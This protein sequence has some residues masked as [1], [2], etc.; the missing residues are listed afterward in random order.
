[1]DE[2]LAALLQF[3]TIVFAGMLAMS[4]AY[5]ALVIVGAAHINPFHGAEGAVKGAVHGMAGAVKGAAHVVDGGAAKANALTEALA[6]LGLSRVPIT[7]S[8]SVFSLFAWFIS[9][10]TRQALDASLGATLSTLAASGA[11][12]AGGFVATALVSKPIAGIFTEP[13]GATSASLTGKTVKVTTEIADD[14][15]GQGEIDDGGAGITIT[16]RTAPGVS[17]KRGDEALVIEY[18]DGAGTYLVEPRRAIAPTD[19]EL[20]AAPVE[21]AV[22]ES[23]ASTRGRS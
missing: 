3:P 9:I 12:L 2:F 20:L 18:D 5:W 21:R 11:A 4:L 15:R 19:A 22:D 8:F 14:Q 17:L 23:V 16:I 1:M 10:A 7:I 13:A 6:F